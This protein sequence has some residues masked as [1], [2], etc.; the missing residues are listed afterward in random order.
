MLHTFRNAAKTWVVKLLFALLALSFVAW[1][2]G[3]FV[4]RSAMGTGPAITVGGVD[5]SA[6]E[7]NM[8]FKREIERLQ[9]TFK[10]QLTEETARKIGYLDQTIQTITTRL[11]VD[12]AT[13]SLGLAASDATVLKAVTNDPSLKNEQGLVDRERLRSALARMGMT[14]AGFLKIARAEQTRNQLAQS[15]TGGVAA[16]MTLVDPLVRRRYEQR[17]AEAAFVSDT[18]V[19]APSAPAQAELETYYSDHTDK[20]MAPEYRALTVLKLRPADVESQIQVSDEDV[21]AAYDQHQAEYNAPE[22]RQSSQILIADQDK[23][24]KAAEQVKQG[25]DITA[26][27]KSLDAKIIDLGVVDK[28]ELPQELQD[29]VFS[30]ASGTTVGPVKSDLGWHVIKVY[31]IIPA[32]TKTLEQVKTQLTEKVRTDKIVDQLAELSNKVEDALGGGASIEE[33]ARRFSLSISTFDAVDAKGLGLNGKAVDNLPKDPSFLNIAFHTDQGAE[34]QMA[35]N[36]QDGYFLIRVDGITAPAPK[37]LA[38]VKTEAVAAWSSAKRHLVA[39]EKAE[40]VAQQFKGAPL[41]SLKGV[42]IE[43]KTTQAFTRDAGDS[44]GLPAPV[45]GKIFES[46]QGDI[47]TTELADGW[48]V[49][50]LAQIKPTEPAD[51]PDQIQTVRHAVSQ[52]LAGD[53][54][55]SFLSALE[56][57]VGVKIDRSQVTHEE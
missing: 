44:S 40:S 49:A 13:K 16:P 20:F 2:V 35:E 11:L 27:A 39:K 12:N 22:K 1:G 17:I 32:Q 9:A 55:D 34:S 53:L 47:S 21:S 4:K 41:A 29:T 24:D 48:V 56:A 25:R 19:P 31:Q 50:R 57:K 37:P 10:G 46:A 45:V 7:V 18:A 42:G 51:H 3:D 38:Q 5:V 43:L 36:G 26:I 15:L 33:A 52:A 54:S 8:E 28:A 23:A 30:A 6:T 14:E